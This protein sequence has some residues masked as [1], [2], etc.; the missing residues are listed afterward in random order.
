[1]RIAQHRQ[2]IV[3]P[4][5]LRHFF[6]STNTDP[7]PKLPYALP[8]FSVPAAAGHQPITPAATIE[9]AQFK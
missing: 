5:L 6:R 1:V 4:D 3:F 8:G 2:N 7:S 9:K